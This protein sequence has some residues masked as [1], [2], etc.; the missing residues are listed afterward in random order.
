MRTGLFGCSSACCRTAGTGWTRI[1]R[2][3]RKR[4]ELLPA[5]ESQSLKTSSTT[6]DDLLVAGRDSRSHR[7]HRREW[8]RQILR[9]LRQSRRRTGERYRYSRGSPS[10]EV[11]WWAALQASDTAGEIAVSAVKSR[12]MPSEPQWRYSVD[13]G[14]AHLKLGIKGTTSGHTFNFSELFLEVRPV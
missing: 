9:S 8:R 6:D 13:A 1:D 12:L 2:P 4:Q 7:L 3:D 11:Q 10:T 5:V 14:R